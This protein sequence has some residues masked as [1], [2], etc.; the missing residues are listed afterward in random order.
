MGTHARRQKE[1]VRSDEKALGGKEGKS[2]LSRLDRCALI[3]TIAACDAG[4]SVRRI[5]STRYDGSL[6]LKDATPFNG[7]Q[8]KTLDFPAASEFSLNTSG[9]IS[10]SSVGKY[11]RVQVRL[12]A[13]N[14]FPTSTTISG[15]DAT[16][17]RANRIFV[18]STVTSCRS[19]HR[20]E[21]RDLEQKMVP[22]GSNPLH[23]TDA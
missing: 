5:S 4:Q 11:V 22:F 17:R 9:K 21:E 1:A 19:R 13:P 12:S 7:S 10:K 18:G 6:G 23:P 14:F 16:R 8:S 3:L 2:F 15:A 20:S